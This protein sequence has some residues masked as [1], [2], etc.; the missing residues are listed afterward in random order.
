MKRALSLMLVLV[1]VIGLCACRKSVDEVKKELIKKPWSNT[2]IEEEY[3]E[4]HWSEVYTVTEYNFSN[5]GSVGYYHSVDLY[6]HSALLDE[7]RN[8]TTEKKKGTYA[9]D[10][11]EIIISF[12]DGRDVFLKYSYENGKLT[13][14]KE[15][16][17]G[18]I[19]YFTPPNGP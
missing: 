17:D 1:T 18:G 19:M 10:G 9:I 11:D 8:I 14:F 13:L 15:T 2:E 16:Y 7:S 6:F 5:N 3:A 4:D 12:D